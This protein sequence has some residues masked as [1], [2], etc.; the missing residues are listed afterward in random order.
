[1]PRAKRLR[2]FAGPNGS[3]K[4][5]LYK[6]ISS[7]FNTGYFVNSDEIEQDISKAGFINLNRFGL[8]LTQEDLDQFLGRDQSIAYYGRPKSQDTLYLLLSVK[9]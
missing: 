2:V 6:Q 1:M 3:G 5:T 7:Q 4:S 8:K 9:I